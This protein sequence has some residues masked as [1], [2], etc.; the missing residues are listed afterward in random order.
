MGWV[1][2]GAPL[3]S[4]TPFMAPQAMGMIVDGAGDV[5]GPYATSSSAFYVARSVASRRASEDQMTEVLALFVGI[6]AA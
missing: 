5:V 2:R 1:T 6:G 3:C 4:E